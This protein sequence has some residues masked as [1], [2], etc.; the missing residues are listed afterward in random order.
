MAAD[1]VPPRGRAVP[2]CAECGYDLSGTIAPVGAGDATGAV[3]PRCPECGAV[4]DPASVQVLPDLPG[5]WRL[6]W[7]CLRPAGA[8]LALVLV[9]GVLIARKGSDWRMVLACLGPPVL[10]TVT[11]WSVVSFASAH[12]VAK[13]R[14]WVVFVMLLGSLAASTL[15]SLACALGLGTL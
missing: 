8:Y 15:V 11:L 14:W 10:L 6:C 1:P 2:R 7:V 4:F 3:P 9:A 12:Y 13:D 5:F